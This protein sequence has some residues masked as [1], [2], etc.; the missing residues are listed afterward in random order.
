MCS[1]TRDMPGGHFTP[2]PLPADV[3]KKP[4]PGEGLNVNIGVVRSLI[5]SLLQIVEFLRGM[6]LKIGR[7]L[8]EL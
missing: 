2:P 1:R 8:M 7:Y 6:I 4:L 5:I 3:A